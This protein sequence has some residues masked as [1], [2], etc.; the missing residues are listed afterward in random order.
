[1]KQ[2]ESPVTRY[3]IELRTES[4]VATTLEV[5]RK[6]TDALRIEVAQFVGELLKDH[7]AQIWVDEDWRVDATDEK[8]LI[9]FV[10]HLF[11]SSTAATMPRR[12]RD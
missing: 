7:A 10:M 5:E 3:N 6:D 8:G 11:A 1:V 4:H 12:R 9:L 2:S